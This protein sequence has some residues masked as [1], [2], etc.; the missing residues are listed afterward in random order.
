M[1]SLTHV[2]PCSPDDFPETFHLWA[3][4]FPFFPFFAESE[5]T[6]S[7]Y[8][9]TSHWLLGNGRTYPPPDYSEHLLVLTCS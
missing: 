8:F 1:V 2:G 6:N 9:K 7:L 3:K 5:R 4:D